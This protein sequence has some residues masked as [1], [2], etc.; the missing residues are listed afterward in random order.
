M[1]KDPKQTSDKSTD[2][3]A[4]EAIEHIKNSPLEA[5]DSFISEDEDRVTVLRAWEEKQQEK[6]QEFLNFYLDL[7]SRMNSNL[8]KW[9]DKSKGRV[10]EKMIDG[11][12]FLPDLFYLMIKLL[13][14]REVPTQNKG[15]LLA[16]I[17]YIMS[18]VD[19][20]PDFLPIVG[21][22]DD[23]V[24]AILALNKFLDVDDDIIKEKVEAYWLNDKDFFKTFKHLLEV[25]DQTIEF[26]PK[27]FFNVIRG[28]LSSRADSIKD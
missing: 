4:A 26:L 16:G 5:L 9:K 11:F 19:L 12:L 24:V 20:L 3:L 18:P 13:F 8:N 2:L 22:M 28:I 17:L 23:L 1:N 25:G 7:R 10:D 6:K 14:D 27:K 21:W 15:A